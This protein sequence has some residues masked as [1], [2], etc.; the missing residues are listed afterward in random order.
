ML[1]KSVI[2]VLI[3]SDWNLKFYFRKGGI[4]SLYVL[5]ESDWNLKSRLYRQIPS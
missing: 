4:M 2:E 3:E 1:I 5:I